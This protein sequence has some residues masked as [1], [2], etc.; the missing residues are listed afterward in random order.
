M[1]YQQRILAE[2]KSRKLTP[3][4]ASQISRMCSRLLR[5]GNADIAV[6]DY[7]QTH[8]GNNRRDKNT[9]W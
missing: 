7:L 5:G 2:V 1:Y 8:L 6:A 4:E 3:P 9:V